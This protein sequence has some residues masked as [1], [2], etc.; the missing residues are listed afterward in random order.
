MSTSARSQRMY[1]EQTAHLYDAMQVSEGDEHFVALKYISALVQA[2]SFSSILDVGCG[3][4]RGLSYFLKH[5]P[6]ITAHGVEPVEALR[7]WAIEQNGI[8]SDLITLGTGEELPFPEKSFDAVCEIGVLHHVQRPENVVS[9][10]MR[11]A[12]KAIFLSDENRFAHGSSIARWGKLALCKMGLFQAAYQ[13]KTF[14]RGHRFSEG[15]GIAYSYSVY[16]AM[17]VLCEWGGRVMLIPTD[18]LRGSRSWLHPL[19]TSFHVLLCAFKED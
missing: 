13:I 11:V 6:G 14:G 7:A 16:D 10:M 4:G 12:R 19:M 8:P 18:D 17:D 3:T 1:Y 2:H 5:L 15:D 9:E